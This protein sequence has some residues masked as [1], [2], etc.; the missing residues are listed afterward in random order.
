MTTYWTTA[1]MP[2]DL[3]GKVYVITG[4]SSGI[5]TVIAHE[6][7]KRGAS[8]VAGNRSPGKAQKALAALRP[9]S[10]GS[11]RFVSLPLDLASL[12]SVREFAGIVN[13]DARFT[14]I[15]GLFLNAGIMALPERKLSQDG[16]ELQMATNVLGHHLLTS[17][18]LDK[19]KASRAGVV[20]STS[21]SASSTVRSPA[22]W[23]DLNAEAKYDA[24]EVYG[25][26]KIAAVQ[27]RDGLR[28]HLA[29]SAPGSKVKVL[30]THPGLTA[31]PLFDVSRGLIAN[32]FRS[33][34]G[35][36]MMSP[37]QGAL[38]SLRAV[39]DQSLPD[40]SFLGPGGISGLR[41]AP[42]IIKEYNPKFSLDPLLR[43]KMWT[44][45]DAST[46]AVWK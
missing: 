35:A 16:F 25:V 31:T 21:S 36:F 14:H 7:S 37:A 12:A 1:N 40:G 43:Q 19:V 8:V 44:Y 17:L 6:L 26:S 20:V 27:F 28:A 10:V 24:W 3:T 39:F 33:I 23:D 13:S 30:A 15:D 34:K 9:D 45:C 42:K 2:S 41:G 32:V 5:G 11:S 46:Q 18:L 4:T 29:K 38:S 22:I